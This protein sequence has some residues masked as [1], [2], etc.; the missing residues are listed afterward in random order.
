ME[1][2]NDVLK[3]SDPNEVMKRG[4]AL[5]INVFLSG[6]KD[7]KYVIQHPYTEKLINFGQ[8]GYQDATKHNDPKRIANFKKRNA[9]WKDAP[10]YSPA[11]LA[12]HLLW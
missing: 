12:Y 2:Y 7:K 6:R 10:R 3:Y 11:W 5:G 1:K 8:M 9:R 4:K